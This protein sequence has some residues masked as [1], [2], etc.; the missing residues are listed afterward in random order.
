M[1]SDLTAY[2]SG[3][4]AEAIPTAIN[5][6][7][8]QFGDLGHTLHV[9]WNVQGYAQ[10]Q[11]VPDKVM[12]KPKLTTEQAIA[13]LEEL[14]SGKRMVGT[15]DWASIALLVFQIIAKILGG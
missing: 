3:L 4:S 8:G 15:V 2:P 14:Q 9:L 12:T 7:K 13:Q 10:S 1:A 5:A 6:L 11:F